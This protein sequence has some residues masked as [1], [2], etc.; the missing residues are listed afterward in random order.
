M[1]I[2]PISR[3]ISNGTVGLPPRAFDFH[4]QYNALPRAPRDLIRS[5]LNISYPICLE[6]PDLQPH[7]LG[8]LW[9][10]RQNSVKPINPLV[11]GLTI[12]RTL[13]S[14]WSRAK[15]PSI[16]SEGRYPG[17]TLL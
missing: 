6:P 11:V 3:R 1:L 10:G 7:L 2:S 13:S 14:G 15:Y 9:S 16:L 17:L 4:R 8:R 5:A 12:S